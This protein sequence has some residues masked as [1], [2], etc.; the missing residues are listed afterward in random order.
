MK[1]IAFVCL[2]C[3][4]FCIS[5]KEKDPVVAQYHQ[6]KLYLSEL[7]AQM[8][9]GLA[10]EDSTLLARQMIEDWLTD[11]MILEEADKVLPLKDKH[12]EKEMSAYRKTLLRQRFF[13][14]LTSDPKLFQV[15]DEE[16]KREIDRHGNSADDHREIV[17]LNYVKLSQQSPYYQEVKSILFDEKRRLTEKK[18]IETVCGDSL[19]YFIEDDKWLFW[20]DVHQEIPIDFSGKDKKGYDYPLCYEKKVGNEVYLLVILGYKSKQAGDESREYVE[21]IR[22]MLEQQKKADFIQKYITKL[23]QQKLK[24]HQ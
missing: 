12:F 20:R 15:S 1:R 22:T 6:S 2:L 5:C 23:A 13:D 14:Y 7:R 11:Q 8:P 16:V 24:A 21:S 4:L 9:S 10:P 3:C 18:R 17:Q 19:E